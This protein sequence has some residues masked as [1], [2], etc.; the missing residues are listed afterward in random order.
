MVIT[1]SAGTIF[2]N[3]SISTTLTA[4]VYKAGVE[5]TSTQISSLGTI[6]W[7]KN[8]SSTAE[9]TTGPTYSISAGNVTNKATFE[10]RLESTTA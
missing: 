2:K 10:A 3:A 8:G 4:H 5:L 1:S 6:K 9:S 7:Y